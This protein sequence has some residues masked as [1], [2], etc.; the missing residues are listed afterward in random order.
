MKRFI[1]KK[2]LT[3]NLQKRNSNVHCTKKNIVK[4]D[5]SKENNQ[6]KKDIEVMETKEKIKLA[7]EILNND[8]HKVK[9]LKKDKSI[10]ERTESSKTIIT[11]DNK[12]LLR[13]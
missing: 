5:V 12:E 2:I 8:Q 9:K 10:I 11:E 3:K 7:A 6:V 1:V 4:C 13:D